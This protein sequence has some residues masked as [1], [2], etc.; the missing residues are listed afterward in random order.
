MMTAVDV[1][2]WKDI[3]TTKL[4][5]NTIKHEIG[6]ALGLMHADSPMSLM[7]DDQSTREADFIGMCEAYLPYNINGLVTIF[8]DEQNNYFYK[9]CSPDY[10]KGD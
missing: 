3:P 2:T 6:H 4:K 10:E 8:D 5:Y 7:Y 1:M 9:E